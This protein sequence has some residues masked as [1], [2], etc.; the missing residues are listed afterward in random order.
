ME[1]PANTTT[2]D[3]NSNATKAT[4]TNTSPPPSPTLSHSRASSPSSASSLP[5]SGLLVKKLYLICM[6]A[7]P[8][9]TNLVWSSS[10]TS[11][12][13]W[14]PQPTPPPS[15]V[16]DSGLSNLD[17]D[18]DYELEEYGLLHRHCNDGAGPA[19]EATWKTH[20]VVVRS[21]AFKNVISTVMGDHSGWDAGRFEGEDEWV[22]RGEDFGMLEDRWGEFEEY[23]EGGHEDSEAAGGLLEVLEALL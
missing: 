17:L 18:L 4:T 12:E 3:N 15:T 21:E 8:D 19:P 14:P 5:P 22:L 10:P 20:D 11:E 7:D 23:S 2:T 9:C 1:S 13:L 6:C 16:S